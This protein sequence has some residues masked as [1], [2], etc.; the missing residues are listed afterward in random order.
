MSGAYQ[1]PIALVGVFGLLISSWLLGYWTDSSLGIGQIVA[2]AFAAHAI[3]FLLLMAGQSLI[4]TLVIIF[5]ITVIGLV[6]LFATGDTLGDGVRLVIW[7]VLLGSWYFPVMVGALAS[8][9]GKNDKP[10]NQ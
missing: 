8:A 5:V 3:G 4:E 7:N 2:N 1:K 10:D 6:A 9:L